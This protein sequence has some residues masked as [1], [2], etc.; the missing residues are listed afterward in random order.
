MLFKEI[1]ANSKRHAE[2][3]YIPWENFKVKGMLVWMNINIFVLQ[4]D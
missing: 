4:M 2:Y 3:K 1:I